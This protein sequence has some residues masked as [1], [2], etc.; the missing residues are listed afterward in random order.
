MAGQLDLVAIIARQLAREL[1]V[2]A[3]LIEDL[4]SAGREGLMSAAQRFDPERGV[5][6]R[7]FANYRVRGAMIDH[8]RRH[9]TLCRS[10]MARRREVNAGEL[11]SKG[12]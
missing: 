4:E 3:R 2:A 6:F 7:R 8:L 10:A 9:A 11:T 1:G 5:P 12:R